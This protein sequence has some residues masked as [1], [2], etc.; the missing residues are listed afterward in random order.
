MP[1]EHAKSSRVIVTEDSEGCRS[2]RFSEGGARQSTVWPGEPLRLELPY[3]RMAMVGLAFVPEPESVLVVGLGGGAIPM[4]LRA[5]LPEVH[6]DVVD[7]D[8][9]VVDAAKLYC[10]FEEDGQLRVHVADARAFMDAEGPEY[11]LIILDAFDAEN[12]PRHLATREFLGATRERLARNGA[13][14]GN[15]W[16]SA[17]NPH[18]AA[19]VRT[20]Q[21]SFR[22][23]SVFE[24][25]PTTNRILVGLERSERFTKETLVARA[26]RVERERELPFKLSTMVARRYRPLT[27]RQKGARVLTD[28]GLE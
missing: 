25:P 18:Y 20:Y 13:V 17:A 11:G 10:G 9:E 24:V 3:T 26:E 1:A 23:V 8:P 16:E 28:E 27:Q 14:V 4:F 15:L 19:M 2:L 6:I 22:G 5:V 21:V 7:N 12:I